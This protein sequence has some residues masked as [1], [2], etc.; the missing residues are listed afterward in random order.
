[1]S[2]LQVK[3]RDHVDHS[4]DEARQEVVTKRTRIPITGPR[5]ILN[6]PFTIPGKHLCWINDDERDSISLA[7]QQGYEFVKSNVKIGETT[8]N[9]PTAGDTSV[10]SK[11]VGLGMTAFLMAIP[12]EYY[13]EDMAA[14]ENLRSQQEREMRRGA[15]FEGGYTKK[16]DLE[17]GSNS[18]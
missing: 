12:Q 2:T 1:M 3:N 7:L 5:N 14:A 6:V 9:R 11:N 8:V 17:S 13:D 4:R 15:T 18:K 10:I 16:S